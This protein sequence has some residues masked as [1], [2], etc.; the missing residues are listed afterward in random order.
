MIR[1]MELII[2]ADIY[3]SA[4]KTMPNLKELVSNRDC[5]VDVIFHTNVQ[6]CSIKLKD[7]ILHIAKP[8]TDHIDIS[9]HNVWFAIRS[10][11]IC[12]TA[13]L[14][15]ARCIDK[16]Y[17]LVACS[18]KARVIIG[19][20]KLANLGP[21]HKQTYEDKGQV[22]A[23]ADEGFDNKQ[24]EL[25]HPAFIDRIEKLVPLPNP[26]ME[27]KSLADPSGHVT[28]LCCL[29]AGNIRI[30]NGKLIRGTTPQAQL[31]VQCAEHYC[32]KIPVNLADLF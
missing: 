13:E 11:Y 20:D 1:R 22:I 25:V 8:C 28:H 2:Y 10:Q 16:R 30:K 6:S 12:D 14:D 26:L 15:E 17:T 19:A 32:L 4:F 5:R 31:I 24:I 23:I 9:S 21:K 29:A 27:N 18:N 7:R 3:D